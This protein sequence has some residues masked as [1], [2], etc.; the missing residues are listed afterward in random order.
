MTAVVVFK[1]GGDRLV[2]YFFSLQQSLSQVLPA[3]LQHSA[4]DLPL[5]EQHLLQAS[6]EKAEVERAARVRNDK[7]VFIV[8][9][10]EWI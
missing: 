10:I 9:D 3:S 7:I 6:P 5:S 8:V 1:H 4:Q 2:P